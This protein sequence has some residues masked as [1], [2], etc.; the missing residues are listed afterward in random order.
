MCELQAGV[1][2]LLRPHVFQ[3]CTVP[4]RL[5][6][7]QVLFCRIVQRLGRTCGLEHV[8]RGHPETPTPI[9]GLQGHLVP[10]RFQKVLHV[11][12]L[13]SVSDQPTDVRFQGLDFSRGLDARFFGPN[14]VVLGPDGSDDGLFGGV[15]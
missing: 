2:V 3:R 7:R 11:M 13:N 10:L 8:F 6:N 12:F 15:G 9:E 1:C 5:Q 14:L 4:A